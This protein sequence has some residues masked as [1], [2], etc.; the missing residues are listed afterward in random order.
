[1]EVKDLLE[2]AQLV[3][4]HADRM[5]CKRYLSPKDIVDGS[6]NLNLAFVA[7]IFQKRYWHNLH[8]IYNIFLKFQSTSRR[9]EPTSM[10]FSQ[11]N[12][13]SLYICLEATAQ[14]LNLDNMHVMCKIVVLINE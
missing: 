10:K 9:T 1:M 5:G 4:E 8:D 7:H 3:L 2:R 14:Y 13:F 6:P 11:V 12:I